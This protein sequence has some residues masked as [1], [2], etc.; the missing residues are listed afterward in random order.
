MV[1][2]TEND[3]MTDRRRFADSRSP[4]EASSVSSRVGFF[5]LLQNEWPQLPVPQRGTGNSEGRLYL[6]YMNMFERS[7]TIVAPIVSS[8]VQGLASFRRITAAMIESTN[9]ESAKD[10]RFQS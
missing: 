6:F 7:A 10:G 3:S 8:S 4:L 9:A 5:I 2:S 1:F